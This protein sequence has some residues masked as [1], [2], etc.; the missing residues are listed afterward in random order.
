MMRI[1]LIVCKATSDVTS[2]TFGVSSMTTSLRS[3]AVRKPG[4]SLLGADAQQWHYGSHFNPGAVESE[5]AEFVSILL[6][7]GV[8]VIWMDNDDQGI[9][10]AVFTY[11]ASLLTSKG[12]VLMSPGKRLRAGEQQV[13][14]TF[15]EHQNIPVIGEVSGQARAEA[16]DTLWLADDVLAVG[17]GFRTNALGVS[18]LTDIMNSIGV[19]V[20]HYDLP[21]YQGQDACLHLMSL[22]SLVGVKQALVCL[23]LVPVALHQDLMHMGYEIIAA[24]FEEFQTSHTLSTNVLATAPGRCI[25]LNRIPKTRAVLEQAGIDVTVFDGDALC[26]GCEGGPTC[27]T[28]PILRS[29]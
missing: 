22:V 19:Q 7:Q 20:R 29:A 14:R 26:I 13:H 25:M 9:A 11:D 27:L 10:D 24:P 12:A 16:G 6:Q 8:N 17:R 28:R 2:M 5:H 21:F 15:Y 18:Q 4:T 23:E 3:V 1:T